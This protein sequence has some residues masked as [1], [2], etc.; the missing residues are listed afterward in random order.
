M[1]KFGFILFPALALGVGGLSAYLTREGMKQVYPTLD[2][3]PLTPPGI[4]FPIV[5]AVLYLLMGIG[6]ALVIRKGGRGTRGAALAWAIQLILNFGWSLLFFGRGEY[7]AA[8]ICLAL[9]WLFIVVMILAFRSVSRLA[10][11]LQVPYLLWVSFAC[12]LNYAIWTL[13]R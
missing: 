11:W 4:V 3:P 5:W 9:L 1:K 6:L 8:L 2:K 12:Y 13:N 10:A 7:L